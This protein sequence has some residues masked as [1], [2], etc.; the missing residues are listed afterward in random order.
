[1]ENQV[2]LENHERQGIS[3]LFWV[4]RQI[5]LFHLVTRPSLA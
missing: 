3:L 2:H 1:M 5:Q 4:G